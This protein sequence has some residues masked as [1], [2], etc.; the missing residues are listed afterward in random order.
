MPEIYA[1]GTV[2]YKRLQTD[3]QWLDDGL[4]S[5]YTGIVDETSRFIQREQL[6]DPAQWARFVNQ[7]R[8]GADADGGWRGEYWGKM[9]RGAAFVYA[10][11]RDKALYRILTDTVEDMLT[12]ADEEG[13]ISTYPKESELRDWD[14]WCRKYVLLGLQYYSEICESEDLKARCIAAMEKQVRYLMRFFGPEKKKITDATPIW[15]GLAA[16]SVLEPVVRLY[17]LTGE[18]DY[19][20][21][22]GWIVSLGGTSVA[23]I[24]EIARAG[25]TDPYQF[26]MTKAYEM[27]S[28]F[29]GLLEY[30][31]ATGDEDAKA[32][33][34]HFGERAAAAE[35]TV[36]GSAGCTH[37]LFDHAA[38]RQTDNTCTGVM[39]ET[40]VTV[41][42][43]KFCLQLLCL[44][45]ESCWADRFEQSFYNAYLGAVNTEKK[46]DQ[47]VL[48][49]WP[50]AVPAPLPFD[51]YSP[52]RPGVRGKSV[53]GLCRMADGRYYGCCACIGSAGIGLAPKAA[54]T[55]TQ[56]GTTLN[57][58][59]PGS[60]ETLT[61][62]GKALRLEIKTA[63][64]VGDTVRVKVAPAQPERFSL[65]V[66]IPAWSETAVLTVNGE[67]LSAAP[68]GYAAIDREWQA[69]DE[70][71]LKLDM[72]MR[73]LRPEKWER[74][75]IVADYRW[76]ANYMVPRVIEAPAD[77]GDYVALRRGPLMLAADRRLGREPEEPVSVLC[78]EDGRIDAEP[79][80]ET[81][82]P[83]MAA[84]SVPQ[85]DGTFF[86]AA[87]YASVGKTMDERS[88]CAVWFPTN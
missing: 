42:W 82:F 10:Y 77:I 78:G 58:F 41:T 38:W 74:D 8:T 45:G 12:A 62:A 22:A 3:A 52:L 30:Y 72:S 44:T 51:S 66:R 55:R 5:A 47:S 23:N 14:L 75:L 13:R 29:E 53:G 37:E 57:L 20:D 17:D 18:K 35:I 24:Y 9:M 19:L 59:F 85:T 15:R 28:C 79:L 31:R 11:T 69:G 81:P 27:I 43:M 61:P 7:F 21:F 73:A 60:V 80:A 46:I 70:I 54:V 67:A 86:P 49:K 76:P 25:K 36:I 64:P 32:A 83:C 68:G 56:T 71:E 4:I 50:D 33:V 84:F 48:L 39:Q 87:D 26:P 40:C 16:A 65:A 1:P 6:M 2:H 34:L 88:R 63:Y